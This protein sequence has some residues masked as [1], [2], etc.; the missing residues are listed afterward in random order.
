MRRRSAG[1]I[2]ISNLNQDLKDRIL[3]IN[4][5][6]EVLKKFD[7]EEKR[8]DI[9]ELSDLRDLKTR[10]ET[11]VYDSLNRMYKNKQ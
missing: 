4:V 11:E 10:T 3:N 1:S 5:S 6:K 2:L 8:E 7:E 9:L